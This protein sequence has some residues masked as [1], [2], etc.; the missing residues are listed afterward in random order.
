MSGGGVTGAGVW[1]VGNPTV[2]GLPDNP[3]PFPA[4]PCLMPV[5]AGGC[6]D[7]E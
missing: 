3:L 5:A 4:L 7:P 1:D 2:C 6:A